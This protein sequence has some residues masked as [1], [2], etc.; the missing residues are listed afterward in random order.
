MRT[1]ITLAIIYFIGYLLQDV[2]VNIPVISSLW[3]AF[4]S[5]LSMVFSIGLFLVELVLS[6]FRSLFGL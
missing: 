6:P 2:I 3:Y 1:V 5:L 4:S